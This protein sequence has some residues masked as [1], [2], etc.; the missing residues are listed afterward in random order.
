VIAAVLVGA[1]LAGV[2]GA[3]FGVPVAGVVV[4]MVSFYRLTVEER[5]LRA[6]TLPG[7]EGVALGASAPPEEPTTQRSA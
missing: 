2:W 7:A 3:L 6:A 4:A 1:K 5:R